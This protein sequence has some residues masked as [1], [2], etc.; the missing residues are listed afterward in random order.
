[1]GSFGDVYCLSK[2]RVGRRGLCW[3]NRLLVSSGDAFDLHSI[4]V[5]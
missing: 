3:E 2:D 5:L 1:M 4:T